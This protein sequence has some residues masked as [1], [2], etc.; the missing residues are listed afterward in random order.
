MGRGVCSSEFRASG[1][2]QNLG[3]CCLGFQVLVLKATV[4]RF[5]MLLG[6]G[7]P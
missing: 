5:G 2:G 4:P 1:F 6:L 3:S 7:A